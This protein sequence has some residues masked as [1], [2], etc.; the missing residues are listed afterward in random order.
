[1]AKTLTSIA[2]TDTFQVWL[3]KTNALINALA[4]E[5][6]TANNDANGAITSGNAYM[7]GIL[8]ANILS[9]AGLRGGNVQSSA[10]LA[11]TSNVNVTG[12]ITATTTFSI[13]A[14]VLANTSALNIGNSSV[15]TFANSSKI[16]TTAVTTTSIN[17]TTGD[18]TLLNSNSV[19]SNSVTVGNVS[20]S[21]NLLSIG[22]ST[23]NATMNTTAFTVQNTSGIFTAA[24]GDSVSNTFFNDKFRFSNSITSGTTTQ[25]VDSYAMASYRG[26][27]YLF[28]C[29]DNA[30]GTGMVTKLLCTH[31]GV[32]AFMTEYGE[33]YSDQDLG[34]FNAITNASHVIIQFTPTVA[35]ATVSMAR[36]H[37]G[38]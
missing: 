7:S 11:I 19:V 24:I 38:A 14:N 23:V 29:K 2:I 33:I 27:E 5:I 28:S 9:T 3:D 21:T 25:N 12:Y 22:N 13:G 20:I 10:N 31:N 26:V 34:N 30:N 16:T 35:N 17:A 18:I 32:N 6:V 37:L 36:T 1:M 8:S 15:F 4:T